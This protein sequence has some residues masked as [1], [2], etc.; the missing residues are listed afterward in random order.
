[1]QHILEFAVQ[2]A[3]DRDSLMVSPANRL[4]VEWIDK[5]PEWPTHMLALHGPQ[6]CGKTHLARIW[7]GRAGAAFL[8][9]QDLTDDA[10][11]WLARNPRSV[12]LDDAQAIAGNADDEELLFHLHN[13]VREAGKSLLLVGRDAPA[14]WDVGLPD[15]ASR[16]KAI[17][18]VGVEQPDDVLLGSVLTKLFSDRQLVVPPD[19]LSYLVPRM[20]RSF[21]AAER[22]ASDLDRLSL[23]HH[24]R[25]TVA[26]AG[27]VLEENA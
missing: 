6:G 4:A 25:L 7:Q 21:A 1:M 23:A 12:V 8:M 2:P 18:A 5:W 24:R 20:E 22:I 16:L 10:M 19:V 27:M 13:L 14:R 26:L 15:L 9:P 3:L 11:T 17:S